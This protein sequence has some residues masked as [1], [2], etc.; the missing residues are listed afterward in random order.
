MRLSPMKT[1]RRKANLPGHRIC[2]RC[3][4]ERPATP[5]FFGRE[6]SRPLGISYEC[7]ACHAARKKG[8]DRS[9]ERWSEMSPEQR[10]KRRIVTRRYGRTDKGRAI[11]LRKAYAK[12][13]ACD[14][15]TDELLA[16]IQLPCTYCGTDAAP[17]GLDRIDNSKAH[18]K[19]NVLPAC[20][21]CNF[22]RGDRLSVEEMRRVGV[23]IR[24]I[25]QDRTSNRAGNGDHLEN[26]ATGRPL[27]SERSDPS[28]PP[29]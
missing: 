28:P 6:K 12:I 3:D 23:V 5:E 19:G 27:Q 26:C 17:R 18:V 16:V 24:E 4:Q 10:D 29:P 13:D 2:F 21:P 8:R 15:T 7:R 9:R 14:F 22:A 25:M 20:A 11:Q 1:T